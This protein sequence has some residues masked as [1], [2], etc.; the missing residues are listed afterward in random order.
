MDFKKLQNS[1]ELNLRGVPRISSREA[2]L[3]FQ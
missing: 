2:V 3:L 1:K